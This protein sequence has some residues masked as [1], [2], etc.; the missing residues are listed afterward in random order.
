[1]LA[2]LPEP[3]D[4][5]PRVNIG[6]I[7]GPKVNITLASPE[8]RLRI[9]RVELGEIEP[10]TLKVDAQG[11]ALVLL[12]EDAAKVLS[13]WC[14]YKLGSFSSCV[15]KYVELNPAER[16]QNVTIIRALQNDAAHKLWELLG[17]EEPRPLN[18]GI[19]GAMAGG[20]FF[21]PQGA[22]VAA[23]DDLPEDDDDFD[24]YPEDPPEEDNQP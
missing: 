6:N 8:L 10:P 1:M 12:G 3:E 23:G 20:T 21:R 22:V 16:T 15:V 13:D 11:S 14:L 2:L 9:R 4:F 17:E 19:G 24:D 18:W 7:T 5:Q